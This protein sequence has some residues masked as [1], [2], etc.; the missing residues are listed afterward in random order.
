MAGNKHLDTLWYTRCSVPTPL[1]FAAQFGWID[2]EFK[3]DGIVIKSLRESNDPV[4]RA[5]HYDHNLPHSFR[6]GGSI[7]PIWARASGADTRVIGLSWTDE[8]QA[9]ITLPTSGI[10][11]VRDLRGRRFGLPLHETRIDHN[12]AS[13]LRALLVSLQLDG[14]AADAVERID[15]PDH[16]YPVTGAGEAHEVEFS[17]PARKRHTYANEVFALVRGD[18]D[19]IYVKDVRG[20]EVVK[21]LGAHIVA[22][23]G[24]HPDPFVR[25]SN[26]TPRP[27]TV[28]AN[29]IDEHPEVV[30]RFL[31]RVSEAAAWAR[32][33]PEETNTW[34][35]RETGWSERLVRQS[36]GPEAHLHFDIDLSQDKIDGINILKNFLVEHGFLKN[37]FDTNDWIDSRPLAAIATLPPLRQAA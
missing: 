32:R 1:S 7:P 5:S 9:I 11:S 25:I 31:R 6:Q 30:A 17:T 34:I 8:F 29:T 37:D 22:D 19:A 2:Q 21:L 23:L 14:I 18:V 27:L 13:A 26:C 36:F 28:N 15:L 4:E 33:H 3:P 12:R 35:A 10:R 16:S 20:L 24:F